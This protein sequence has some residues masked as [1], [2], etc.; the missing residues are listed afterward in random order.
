MSDAGMRTI[1]G[2]VPST[3][4]TLRDPDNT[5]KRCARS[6][7]APSAALEAFGPETAGAN[8][9]RI[10]RV[11]AGTPDQRG[12]A[13]GR[14]RTCDLEIRRLLLYPAEL[15]RPARFGGTGRPEPSGRHSSGPSEVGVFGD[16]SADS[17]PR[18]DLES[19]TRSSGGG[20]AGRIVIDTLVPGD[21]GCSVRERVTPCHRRCAPRPVPT[22]AGAGR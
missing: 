3:R 9:G 8:V 20:S 5:R 17:P 10:L 15:R 21:E 1:R 16:R 6:L 22:S 14:T 13:P 11:D 18:N 2:C 7:P 4:G 12:C 19:A